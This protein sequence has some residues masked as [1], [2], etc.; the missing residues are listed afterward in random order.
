M[1][2]SAYLTHYALITA[3][4]GRAL[5]PAY[6]AIH[7]DSLYVVVIDGDVYILNGIFMKAWGG[8]GGENGALCSGIS[9]IKIIT[10]YIDL[11]QHYQ[12]L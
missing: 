2:D 1:R 3:I 7:D 5:T 4:Q 10:M 6:R 8:G 12:R 11:S 9:A